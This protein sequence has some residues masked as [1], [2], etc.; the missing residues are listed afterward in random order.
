MLLI[1][2]SVIFPLSPSKSAFDDLRKI[3]LFQLWRACDNEQLEFTKTYR[4]GL[5]CGIYLCR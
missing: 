3:I 2:F 5:C 4:A 1:T